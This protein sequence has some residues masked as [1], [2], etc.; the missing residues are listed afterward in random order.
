MEATYRADCAQVAST[1]YANT[2][3]TN[4]TPEMQFIITDEKGIPSS[5]MDSDQ[6]QND[7]ADLA[8]QLAANCGDESQTSATLAQAITRHGNDGITYVLISAIRLL[9]D[10]ILG[11]AFD[12]TD[13]ST[14]LNTRAKMAEI[15]NLK[16]P[17]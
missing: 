3:T 7:G 14:G 1:F 15:G 9:T 10:D 13:K 6:I 4:R 8:F 17:N 16:V 12:L 2:S 5:S 11:P